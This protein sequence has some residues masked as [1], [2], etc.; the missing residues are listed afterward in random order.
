MKIEI[1][2]PEVG[3]QMRI[4]KNGKE[5]DI[6]N[7]IEY[8][9]VLSS[10]IKVSEFNGVHSSVELSTHYTEEYDKDFTYSEFESR[11]SAHINKILADMKI[12]G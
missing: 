10:K 3:S 8:V 12:P 6:F 4:A 7:S 1:N 9:K 2:F 5:G 11:A